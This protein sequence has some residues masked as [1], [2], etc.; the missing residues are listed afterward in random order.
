MKKTPE[1]LAKLEE[2]KYKRDEEKISLGIKDR[3]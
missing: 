2:E 3:I 1:E